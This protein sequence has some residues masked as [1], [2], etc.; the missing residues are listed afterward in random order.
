M[1]NNCDKCDI[2]KKI[3]CRGI[4]G[5]RGLTGTLDLKSINS[6]VNK[7]YHKVATNIGILDTGCTCFVVKGTYNKKY[8]LTAAHCVSDENYQGT[9]L[10]PAN[11][12]NGFLLID[13]QV[14]TYIPNLDVVILE[15]TTGANQIK[16]IEGLELASTFIHNQI[17][18]TLFMIGNPA[19]RDI[20][21]LVE[22]QVR[23]NY[24]T[25]GA[26]CPPNDGLH[27]VTDGPI[28]GGNSGSPYINIDGKVVGLLQCS[29]NTGDGGFASGAPDITLKQLIK[30]NYYLTLG[31]NLLYEVESTG[32]L[33][34]YKTYGVSGLVTLSR[35]NKSSP[36]IGD[37]VWR[38]SDIE[39][40]RAIR[41]KIFG[42]LSTQMYPL[43]AVYEKYLN[44]YQNKKLP[45]DD[46]QY[47]LVDYYQ[48]NYSRIIDN[49][50]YSDIINQDDRVIVQGNL[51]PD[52]SLMN[53]IL[54]V[55]SIF[56]LT[57]VYPNTILNYMTE[58]TL[59]FTLQ[60]QDPGN[61]G[62]LQC[63]IWPVEIMIFVNFTS[64]SVYIYN[65]SIS[66]YCLLPQTVSFLPDDIYRITVSM[67]NI[68]KENW[69]DNN[70]IFNF[71]NTDSSVDINKT[72]DISSAQKPSSFD[73]FT[74]AMNNDL[75]INEFNYRHTTTSPTSQ[76]LIKNGRL[77]YNKVEG[78]SPTISGNGQTY[79]SNGQADSSNL[80][81]DITKL[82]DG[83]MTPTEYKT[84]LKTNNE[85]K[86]QHYFKQSQS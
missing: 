41:G 74:T 66:E 71:V 15:E 69:S 68:N 17:G 58:F 72:C 70:F 40:Y 42:P 77:Y 44:Y 16:H 76:S 12:G 31:I 11:N 75:H 73:I 62:L 49:Q 22:V 18:E 20:N 37:I 26:W 25:P 57:Y 79:S 14:K 82:V 64:S 81:N 63:M 53:Y 13:L 84:F 52:S 54:D 80:D 1:N 7:L 38:V 3:Y 60:D 78:I 61:L 46:K 39:P 29:L 67:D 27:L 50:I 5:P 24:W 59:E 8:V 47:I 45:T 6:E 43:Q 86:R 33:E 32:Y 48:V 35:D 4:R 51:S 30:Y 10:F 28:Y 23:N 55:N 65:F 9:A 21:S 19:N 34:Q 85:L 83:I 2:V 36:Q 56:Y